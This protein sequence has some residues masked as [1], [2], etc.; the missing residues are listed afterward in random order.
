MTGVPGTL[1]DGVYKIVV[2][3]TTKMDGHVMGSTMG[4]NTWAAFAGSDEKVVLD[5]DV[6]MLESELQPVLKALRSHGCN[7]RCATPHWPPRP[8]PT[9]RLGC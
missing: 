7:G 1:K 6:A 5:G 9:P 2:G 4:V 8:G 3:R